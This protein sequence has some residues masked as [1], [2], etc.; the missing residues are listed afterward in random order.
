MHSEAKVE[1]LDSAASKI[2]IDTASTVPDAVNQALNVSYILASVSLNVLRESMPA[3]TEGR[4]I[5]PPF[6][7]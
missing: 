5:P 2:S 3:Y 7:L 4:L 6:L 1:A